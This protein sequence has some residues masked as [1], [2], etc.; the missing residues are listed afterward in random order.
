MTSA[1]RYPGYPGAE[2]PGV[3]ASTIAMLRARLEARAAGYPV[4]LTTDPAWCIDVAIARRARWAEDPHAR[5]IAIPPRGRRPAR[6][7]I[8]RKGNGDGERF[9]VQL[10]YQ[11]RSRVAVDARRA[12]EYAARLERARP[13]RLACPHDAPW[14]G[15]RAHECD[16]CRREYLR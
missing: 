12:A 14:I 2:R 8:G 5:V 11:I 16:R 6:D 10:A 4:A 7:G 3:I 1:P 13:G 9:A 15:T